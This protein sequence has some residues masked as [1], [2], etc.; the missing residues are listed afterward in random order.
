MFPMNL[1]STVY[2]Q[3]DRLIGR[4]LHCLEH[5]I[6][7]LKLLR[8]TRFGFYNLKRLCNI[9]YIAEDQYVADTSQRRHNNLLDKKIKEKIRF[10]TQ[11][12]EIS[13]YFPSSDYE[14]G[15]CSQKEKRSNK[16][17]IRSTWCKRKELC[18]LWL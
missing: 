9:Y 1:G 10:E 12:G 4:V 15:S 14:I 2:I 17:W 5:V 7:T 6:W 18:L 3:F 8:L 16:R 13:T 11:I